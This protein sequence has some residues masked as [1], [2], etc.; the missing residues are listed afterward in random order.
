[1]DQIALIS[2]LHGNLPALE[3]TLADI[4][5]R[6][7]DQIFCLGDLVGKG[8]HSD[9]VVDICQQVCTRVVK[10]NW[11][12]FIVAETDKPTMAWHR[13]RLGQARLNYLKTLPGTIDFVMSGKQV[14][15]FHASPTSVYHRV[16]ME[17]PREKHLEM[18]ANTDFTGYDVVPDVVGY[19]DIHAAY[20]KSFQHRILFNVGS[21]GNPLDLTLAAYAILEGHYDSAKPGPFSVQ[22]MRLPYDIDLAIQQAADEAMPELDL[23]ANELR[24]ARYRGLSSP[25][26]SEVTT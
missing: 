8:P 19:G 11:D 16:R 26:P 13:Q 3:V 17:D 1:M 10:G 9:T 6:K 14:R 7:I 25:P 22:M 5:R 20:L 21:V 23:Y 24:T 4:Q 2:D 18:F 15:L 12:D